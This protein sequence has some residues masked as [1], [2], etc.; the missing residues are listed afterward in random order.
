MRD[1]RLYIEAFAPRLFV[2]TH[3]DN[4]APGITT[5]GEYYEAPLHDELQRMPAEQRPQVRF[6]KDPGDYLNPPV[7]TFPLHLADPRLVR[8]CLGD[9]RLRV[10]LR[11]ELGLVRGAQ[12]RFDA[13]RTRGVTSAPYRVTFT[14]AQL[15]RTRSRR[16]AAT[17]TTLDGPLAL[18]R[19]LPRCGLR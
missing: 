2:P 18:K 12:F 13:K 16:L 14:R 10:E 3:H 1:V 5:T 9:G 11:G 15:E 6:I 8:R 7:L 19:T 17:V 4:W